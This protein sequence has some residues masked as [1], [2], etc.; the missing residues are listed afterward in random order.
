MMRVSELMEGAIDVHAHT[1]PS[2]FPRINDSFEAAEE[3]RIMGLRAIVLKNHHGI[4][5]DRA[6]LVQRKVPGIEVYGGVVLNLSVGGINPYAVE[7]ALM[8][9]RCKMVWLPTQT[10]QH[11]I[12]TYG[13]P[14]GYFH[15]AHVARSTHELKAKGIRILDKDGKITK[16]TKEVISLVKE[17]NIGIAAGH[18]SKKEIVNFMK[19]CKKMGLKRGRYMVNHVALSELWTWSIQ[20]QKALVD[21]GAFIEHTAIHIQPNRYLLSP[22]NMAEMIKRVGPKNIVISTDCG[23]MKNPTPA[24]GFRIVVE[25][26]IDC[27]ISPEEMKRMI[28]ENPAHL[29][30]V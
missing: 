4:T 19:E 6:T 2:V 17:A 5:A 8:L 28:R 30:S 24:Q 26:L 7:N 10:A 27:G 12:D 1:G 23:Q 29:I 22:Q 11:H 14:H 21:A 20:E 18:V 25:K 13:T 16:E 15:M 3:G 9:G